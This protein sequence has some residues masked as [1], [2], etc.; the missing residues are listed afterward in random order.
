STQTRSPAPNHAESEATLADEDL[1][2]QSVDTPSRQ[3]AQP[4]V[5]QQ[6]PQM[7]YSYS[8][9]PLPSQQQH[10]LAPFELRIG[11]YILTET[12]GEGT[13]GKVKL[14][15][16]YQNGEKCAVKAIQKSKIKTVKQMNSVQREVRLMKLLKHPHIV[17]VKETLEDSD[18]VCAENAIGWPR[19]ESHLANPLLGN[20]LYSFT[21][22]PFNRYFSLWNMQVG[23]S[24]LTTLLNSVN[25][26]KTWHVFT[27]VK[28][29][30]PSIIAIM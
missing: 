21:C 26:T 11:D 17:D 13:F 29:C 7:G 9:T 10:I 25:K 16:H 20:L 1:Q 3:A 28:L 15:I 2:P 4:F 24:C 18:Q 14:G 23:G 30:L 22:H 19:R 27:F 5:Q 6:Q 8:D 12:I